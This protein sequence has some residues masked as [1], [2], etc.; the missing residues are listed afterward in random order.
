M[1]RKKLKLTSKFRTCSIRF[2]VKIGAKMHQNAQICK[3]NFKNFLGAMPQ[4]PILGTGYGAPPQT[5]PHRRS[6]ASRFRDS[7]GAFGHSIVAPRSHFPLYQYYFASGATGWGY[8]PDDIN[9]GV[10]HFRSL[11][12]KTLTRRLCAIIELTQCFAGR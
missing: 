11:K 6:D 5:S 2:N 9:V 1:E 8:R 12:W 3:L 7:L 4:T 10:F